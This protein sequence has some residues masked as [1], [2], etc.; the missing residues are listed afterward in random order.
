MN[1]TIGYIVG[2]VA[3][4][5]LVLG[6]VAINRANDVPD[7]VVGAVGQQGPKGEKGDRGP[8]GPQG[9]RGFSGDSGTIVGSVTGPDSYFPYYGRNDVR[10]YTE[11]KNFAFIQGN[12]TTTP[13]A[14]KLPSATS[15]V[16]FASFANTTSTSTA[17]TLTIATSTTP[18]ATT[19]ALSTIVIPSG[20]TKEVSW[21]PSTITGG[22]GSAIPNTYLVF[23]IA[24]GTG[25]NGTVISGNCQYE[26][27]EL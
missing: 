22:V 20:Q 7:T 14:F 27:R 21:L 9:P 2:F 8:A 15:T 13:C 11:S 16:L 23:G 19:T 5:G 18:Y 4:A 17:L 25:P 6:G 24:G 26:A 3:V 12:A 10:D 1:K